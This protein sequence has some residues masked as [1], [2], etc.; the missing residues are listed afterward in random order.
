MP[1]TASPTIS[2]PPT[3][4]PTQAPKEALQTEVNVVLTIR[5]TLNRNMTADEERSFKD[6]LRGFLAL[7]LT[8]ELDNVRIDKVDMWYQQTV[9]SDIRRLRKLQKQLAST[10]ITLILGVTYYESSVSVGDV[11]VDFIEK[12]EVSIINLFRG[13]EANQFLYQI[14][15]L[16]IRIIDQVTLAP[17]VAPISGV[18]PLGQRSAQK[19]L[20]GGSSGGGKSFS[21]HLLYYCLSPLS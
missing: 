17:A 8:L 2:P 20:S 21:M 18:E 4:S 9:D 3:A 6:E 19:N 7:G 11:I 1:T 5:N 15:S 10:A 12:S 13:N 14:D 16:K